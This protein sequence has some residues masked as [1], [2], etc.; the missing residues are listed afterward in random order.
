MALGTGVAAIVVS[1]LVLAAFLW[2]GSAAS[3]VPDRPPTHI[4]G[5][6]VLINGRHPRIWVV[7]DGRG[8]FGGM[9][10]SRDIRAFYAADQQ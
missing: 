6:R 9:L 2:S 4:D 7:D 8:A 1:A 10:A 3:G 5:A